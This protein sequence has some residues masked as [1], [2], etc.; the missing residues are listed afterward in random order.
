MRRAVITGLGP[1]TPIGIGKEAFWDGLVAGRSA[2]RRI[3]RFDASVLRSQIAAEVDFDPVP[4]FDARTLKRLDRFSQF[5]VAAARLAVEDAGL[6]L[7]REDGDRVGVSL[8]TALGGTGFGEMQFDNFKTRGLRGVDPTLAL[9]VFGG[10]GSCNIAIALGC[11]GPSTANANSCASGT[12]AI[13][14]ALEWIRGDRADVV[15]AGGA[16]APLAPLCYGAFTLI[17]AMSCRNDEPERACRP[18]DA[19]RDGFIMGEGAALLVVEEL[20]HARARGAR[21]YGE[22]LGSG[23]TNDAFHMTAPRPDGSQAARAMTLALA[24]AGILPGEI[25]YVNAHGSSTPLNDRTETLA[26][27]R[28][29]GDDARR[30]PVSSTK[31]HHG[32]PLGAAGA[33]EAAAC[34]LAME[35]GFLPPTVNLETPDPEC[36]LDFIPRAGRAQPA[37][38]VLSNSFG[39][40][41][42][43]A[44]VVLR[45]WSADAPG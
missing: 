13:G 2:V 18:F 17:R 10:A 19:G 40:G 35:R 30:L 5:S 45:R 33:I 42:I 44:C 39:F 43:N 6:V 28:V 21:I 29:F 16:E 38:T 27:K 31:G 12:I 36:D 1:V 20:E 26:L 14:Q 4:F 25:D 8:G 41:G 11:A 9:L 24:D 7:E 34:L 23:M 15:L 3:T 22:I 37:R 32:H